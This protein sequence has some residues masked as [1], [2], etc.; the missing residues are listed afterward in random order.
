MGLGKGAGMIPVV[1]I[2]RGGQEYLR[3]AIKQASRRNEVAL[4]GDQSNRH[5]NGLCYWFDWSEFTK[6]DR[7]FRD[8]LGSYVQMSSGHGEFEL[9]WFERWFAIRNWMKATGQER[10]FHCDSDVM[11]YC[12][13]NEAVKTWDMPYPYAA[14]QIPKSQPDYRWSASAHCSYWTKKALDEFCR[15]SLSAYMERT[16][17]INLNTL[18]TKWRWHQ[19]M[20][21]PGGI[22]DM[23]LLYLWYSW[24]KTDAIAFLEEPIINNGKVFDGATFDH[25]INVAENYLPDEY[26]MSDG[27]IKA[28]ALN[29]N[30][31]YMGWNELKGEPVKFHALHFQGGAK[32]LMEEYKA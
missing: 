29:N 13:V 12:D 11:L 32:G 9:A 21:Q 28:V 6:R 20:R 8:F 14:F 17:G 23:T 2:H 4:L 3:T 16:R 22:C 30:G 15:F 26:A 7:S 10:I 24:R 25:N 18:A 31:D 5:L 27:G 19:Q 1:F